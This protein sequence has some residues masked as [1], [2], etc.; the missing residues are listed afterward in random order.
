M[1]SELQD[2][3]RFVAAVSPFDRVDEAVA[4]RLCDGAEVLYF[5]RGEYL[6]TAGGHNG[7]LYLVRTGAVDLFEQDTDFNARLDEG[8]FF[9]YPSLLRDG[10][11]RN[12]VKAVEDTLVYRFPAAAFKSAMAGSGAVADFFHAAEADR[13]RA[14]LK[15]RRAGE[16]SGAGG[17]ASGF[18]DSPLGDVIA[19]APVVTAPTT[20]V[21]EAAR[22]MT[23]ERV[24]TLLVVD[25]S[26]R[27]VGLVSDQDMRSR[28]LAQ[29]LSPTSPLEAIMTR[30]LV[31]FPP[32]TSV[33]DA[34]LAMMRGHFRHVP[35]V[36]GQGHLKGLVSGTDLMSRLAT[37]GLQIIRAVRRAGSVAEISALAMTQRRLLVDLRASG[38]DGA[39]IARLL[40]AT[41]LAIHR[42]LF[43]LAVEA[44]GPPP[45]K[46]AFVCFGSLAR[47][48]QTALSDQDNGFILDNTYDP[49]AHG[50]AIAALA[51]FIS[52]GLDACG[53]V[54][55]KGGI[56][57]TRADWCQPISTWCG[58][59]DR[60]IRTPEPK[61]LMHVS[62]FFD[63]GFVAG[64]QALADKLRN[65]A[66]ERCAGAGIFLAHMTENALSSRPP[67]GIFRQFVVSR[68]GDE[69][70]TLDLKKQAIV[71]LQDCVRVHALAG[72][73]RAVATM[74]RLEQLQKESVLS[75]TDAAELRDAFT[76]LMDVRVR[77]QADQAAR[78]ETPTNFVNPDQLSRFE[79]EHL[80]AAFK[81]IRIHQEG[82]SRAYAGGVF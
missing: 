9:A 67:L 37:S 27:L 26:G 74:D 10:Q 81:L 51:Q 36:D 16:V 58:Y 23:A 38:L 46:L 66:A 39:H 28:V 32:E 48:E 60:W 33:F 69:D 76:F 65:H 15:N 63:M 73:I 3:V 34:L 35:V 31:T 21:N 78:G 72:G 30:D 64:D 52:D 53:Y 29:D 55:C 80:R 5:R 7:H 41:G 70:D 17:T 12:S 14:A 24:S 47:G 75:A 18:L 77:H 4:R 20:P 54:Y 79:R 25:A 62:I 59:F 40:S 56:M 2:I 11:V 61:A 8:C 45:V 6:L 50:T 82:L 68:H 44:L 42:R 49:D 57:A 19:R 71:P 13:L 22:Q 1:T 43:D